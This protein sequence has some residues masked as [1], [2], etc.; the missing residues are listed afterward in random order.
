MKE[1][2]TLLKDLK[3]TAFNEHYKEVATLCEKNG[4]SMEAFLMELVQLEFNK[5]HDN[6]I[7]RLIKNAKIPRDKHLSDFDFKVIP[8]LSISTVNRLAT[9]ECMDHAENILIFGNPG[10]GKT[11]LAI[12]LA[13]EW[14]L[15][16]RKVRFYQA[17]ELVQDLLVAKKKYEMTNLIRRLNQYDILIIDDIS[18]VPFDRKETDVLFNLMSSRYENKSMLITS[19][20]SFS[21]WEPIFKDKMTTAA[22]IDRVVHHSTILELNTKS[23]RAAEAERVKKSLK[24]DVSDDKCN[25]SDS[26]EV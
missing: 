1:L 20:T 17:Y 18:Y 3:L 22:A 11:H 16:G 21:N 10:T 7:K 14:C 4:A 2:E 6:R 9:G 12:A 13:R 8:D 5:R 23:Y 15:S 26:I 24:G 25:D 19:N